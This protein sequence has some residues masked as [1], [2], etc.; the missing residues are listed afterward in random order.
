[1]TVRNWRVGAVAL[2]AAGL[3][4]GCADNKQAGD[5]PADAATATA[6]QQISLGVGVD[7]A[8]SPFYLASQEGLFTKAGLDVKV[9]QYQEGTGGLDAILA[10]QGQVAANTESSLLNRATRGDIKAL[11]V[12]S[13]SP[14]FIKLVA[15]KGIGDVTQIKKYGVVKGTVNEFAT[16]K[17]LSAKGIAK[18]D[19]TFVNASPAEMPALLERGDVDGYIMWEPWPSRGVA[20][21][22]KILLTSGD[23]GYTYNLVLDV[24]G[25]WY[26]S[27]KDAAKKIVD[28]LA[29]ACDTIT[30]D[31]QAA[32]TA[33]EQAIKVPAAEAVTLLDGVQCK[34]RDFTDEDVANYGEIAKFQQENKIVDKAVDVDSVLVRGVA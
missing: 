25:A 15:R 5:E 27:N 33:T 14:S 13:Q 16:N 26:E 17:V 12:F 4:V 6:G 19:V 2:L 28:V 7:P 30:S 21:G 34:V 8:Y 9:M 20:G 10:K 32:G 3:L 18:D 11:A 22:G 24:D 1:M 23:I 31:P 29:E